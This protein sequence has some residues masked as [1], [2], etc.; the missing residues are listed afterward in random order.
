MKLDHGWYQVRIDL[1]RLLNRT[2][3]FDDTDIVE[4]D[5]ILS[6]EDMNALGYARNFPHL[7]CV[8]CA[9]PKERLASFSCDESTLSRDDRT[10]DGKL[11][12]LPATCYK[13][14][15]S[16]R[17]QNLTAEQVCGCIARCF[18]NEDKPLD[19]YRGINFTMKEFVYVG[20][21]NGAAAHLEKG[22]ETIGAIWQRL[23]LDYDIEVATDPFFDTSSSVAVMSRLLPTKR[24]FVFEGHALSSL[25]YHRNYFGEKFGISLHGDPV[26]TS[27]VAFGLERWISMLRQ[28]F[29]SPHEA[30]AALAAVDRSAGWRELA[31]GLE[32]ER[33]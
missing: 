29:P 6:F 15:L 1:E 4:F 12:L 23:D 14:Y 33:G 24:E 2:F 20:T 11:A 18:R 32:M 21:A 19:A 28:R 31:G 10:F 7:T 27:C 22:A 5:S 9:L 17:N 16:L 25:N 3:G 30:R 13:H 8:M 26:H